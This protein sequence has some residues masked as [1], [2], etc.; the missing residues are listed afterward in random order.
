MQRG[1][2]VVEPEDAQVW[3]YFGLNI[4]QELYVDS[5]DLV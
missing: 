2:Q 3:E 4:V 1:N 5:D